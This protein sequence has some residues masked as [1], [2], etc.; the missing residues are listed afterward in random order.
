[1]ASS[2][3]ATYAF[4]GTTIRWLSTQ[5]KYRGIARVYIDGVLEAN[6]DGYSPTTVWQ[7]PLF[8]K[9]FAE[10]GTHTIRI[11]HTGTK[12]ASALAT[13]IEVDA[14]DVIPMG[15]GILSSDTAPARLAES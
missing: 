12:N 9:T 10:N 6:A 7:S 3:S 11:E 5:N 14:F 13:Y 2:G 4:T 8:T 1:M 15:A